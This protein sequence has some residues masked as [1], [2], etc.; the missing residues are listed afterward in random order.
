MNKGKGLRKD[1]CAERRCDDSARV[2][3]RLASSGATFVTPLGPLGSLVVEKQNEDEII[4]TDPGNLWGDS[5]IFRPVSWNE[6]WYARTLGHADRW[7][8][9]ARSKEKISGTQKM[10]G[11]V[12][13]VP[14]F[15]RWSTRRDPG[16][17]Q[18][19]AIF[20]SCYNTLQNFSPLKFLSP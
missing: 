20:C 14:P 13:S 17:Y 8:I 5:K 6:L 15:T 12:G 18:R 2:L 19:I 3:N 16:S 11:L 9:H 4:I 1:S 7:S 10:E